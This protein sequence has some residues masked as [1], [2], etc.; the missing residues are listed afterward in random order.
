MI[1]SITALPGNLTGAHR[2]WRDPATGKKARVAYPRRAMGRLL[3]HGVRFGRAGDTMAAGEGIETIGSLRQILPSLPMI[4][5]LSAAHLAAIEF[6]QCL[7]RL[8]VARDPDPAGDAAFSTLVERASS[9]AIE[10]VSLRATIGD[11][12]DD[13]CRMGRDAMWKSV[14]VQLAEGDRVR[15]FVPGT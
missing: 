10:V 2:T 6:P 8:Y 13:L 1:A 15:F 7:R 12:N 11:F 5:G 14:R 4:A 3:G 9:L